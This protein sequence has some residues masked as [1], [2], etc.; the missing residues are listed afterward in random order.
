MSVRW[1][2][3]PSLTQ[4]VKD[5][6]T[7]KQ[8]GARRILPQRMR[9][10][11]PL[12]MLSCLYVSVYVCVH[13]CV[14]MSVSVTVCMLVLFL[15][16]FLQCFVVGSSLRFRRAQPRRIGRES[17]YYNKGTQYNHF[18]HLHHLLR[19]NFLVSAQLSKSTH[20]LTSLWVCSAVIMWWRL[21]CPM[22]TDYIDS[23]CYPMNIITIHYLVGGMSAMNFSK[24]PDWRNCSI[25]G[26]FIGLRT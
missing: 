18:W 10:G 1:K 5:T 16:L 23:L 25:L 7:A 20:L 2:R 8:P 22:I 6:L 26:Y 9:N 11:M 12:C 4:G 24:A 15:L 21:S 14:Q 19:V 17:A 3:R 13:T